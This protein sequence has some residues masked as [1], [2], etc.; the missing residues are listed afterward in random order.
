MN[1]PWIISRKQDL[2]F[3]SGSMLL[4]HFF[5]SLYYSLNYFA[6]L[7]LAASSVIIYF[8][9]IVIFDG[10]HIFATFTR[11]Y[12]DRDFRSKNSS[13]VFCS[14]LL[15]LVGPLY[16]LVFYFVGT[17]EQVRAAFLIFNRFGTFFAYYHLIR[18]HWGFISL[19]NRKLNN[20]S[21]FQIRLEYSILWLGTLYPL[22][23][24]HI[25]HY[26]P[27]G[28]AETYIGTISIAD[29]HV[30]S[31]TLLVT[32]F[33]LMLIVFLMKPKFLKVSIL[34]I[35]IIAIFA[36]LLIL[37]ILY[38]GFTNILYWLLNYTQ[39]LFIISGIAY[40]VLLPKKIDKLL[41]LAPKL[42]LLGSVL[43]TH[44][45][46]L[47]MKI[48]YTIAYACIVVFHDVQYHRIIRF[49]NENKYNS[50]EVKY[51]WATKL[52]KNFLLFAI[53]AL[54]FNL[55]SSLP[56]AALGYIQIDTL[57]INE[58][59]VYFTTSFLWGIAFHHYVID[60]II[61]RPSK[62]IE[63]KENLKISEKLI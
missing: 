31:K 39:I 59:L 3:I 18:Q 49:H 16:L 56:G 47:T 41:L 6:N 51:G 54:S 9:T 40:V 10:T 36:A 48:P 37:L 7:S 12:F 11:T 5:L 29:W 33:I 15:L 34:N 24:H 23:Y 42:L 46:I 60:A 55:V 27:L 22:I 61:W 8:L 13:L 1:S 53:L 32:S 2:L 38:F 43:L 35:S 25:Y 28:W 14:L 62:D 19:Y 21:L 63:V 52:T 30:V 57:P 44:Y 20:N 58:I 17:E 50:D 45:I 26:Q 4:S